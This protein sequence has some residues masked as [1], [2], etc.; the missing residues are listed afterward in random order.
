MFGFTDAP[1]FPE[2]FSILLTLKPRVTP[3][4]TVF[5]IW[6]ANGAEIFTLEV[7]KKPAQLV[8]ADH[9]GKPGVNRPLRFRKIKL[10]DGR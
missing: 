2:N 6:G 5:S 1:A 3:R 7:G 8:Y 4:E 10:G 9:T